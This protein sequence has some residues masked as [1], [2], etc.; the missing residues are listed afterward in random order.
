M[1]RMESRKDSISVPPT[2]PV[3]PFVFRQKYPKPLQQLDTIY[4]ETI[5]T[6]ARFISLFP[7]TVSLATVHIS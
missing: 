6:F 3:P 4:P 1:A 7:H 2:L 5:F